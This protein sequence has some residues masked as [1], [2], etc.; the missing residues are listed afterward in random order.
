MAR[1]LR[2]VNGEVYAIDAV[3]MEVLVAATAVGG[4]LAFTPQG[5]YLL[6]NAELI[7]SEL[8]AFILRNVIEEGLRHSSKG[9]KVVRAN[10]SLGRLIL[11]S[12]ALLMEKYPGIFVEIGEVNG[13]EV[14]WALEQTLNRAKIRVISLM[15]AT[16]V[17]VL[18]RI[19]Q[20]VGEFHINA[21]PKASG[22]IADLVKAHRHRTIFVVGHVEGDS[23]VIRDATGNLR[24][25][26]AFAKLETA[27]RKADASL[28][29]LGCSAGAKSTASGFIDPVNAF[30]VAEGLK[31][32]IAQPSIGDALSA[33]SANSADLVVRPQ[34]IDS[35]RVML[36]AEQNAVAVEQK[37]AK[38]SYGVMRFTTISKSRAEELDA[39]II[40]GIPSWIQVTYVVGGFLLLFSVRA[41]LRDW[42]SIRAPAPRFGYRPL[43]HIAV[44]GIRTLGFLA[45]MPFACLLG[46]LMVIGAW[47][48]LVILLFA[49]PEASLV[50]IYFGWKWWQLHRERVADEN[51][52]R[53]YLALPLFVIPVSVIVSF[54]IGVPVVFQSVQYQDLAIRIVY[55]LASGSTS[56]LFSFLAFRWLA[57][58]QWVP[59]EVPDLIVSLPIIWVERLANRVI[60]AQREVRFDG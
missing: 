9:A 37:I 58:K 17:D 24:N 45:L 50:P 7:V 34:L 52:L 47:G 18:E 30:R 12:E 38:L 1:A 57:R 23:F 54:I 20:A 26:I 15:D 48:M 43:A 3:G 13:V 27:A 53:R 44:K 2:M 16:D 46:F 60:Y 32:A 10:G 49:I 55:W 14:A 22:D 33:L 31:Q 11:R 19:D 5:L 40:P 41:I 42:R 36:I 29:M 39:R 56:L 51:W 35:V 25:T 6:K 59:C 28:F 21:G 8:D 4:G